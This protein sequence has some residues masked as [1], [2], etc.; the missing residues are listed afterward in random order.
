MMVEQMGMSDVV[1]PRNV[2]SGQQNP[3]MMG[4]SS[5]GFELKNKVDDEIDRILKEQYERGMNLLTEHRDLLDAI[6]NTLIEKEKIDGTQMLNIIKDL[7]PNLVSEEALQRAKET[8][9]EAVDTVTDAVTGGD[10]QT[11]QPAAMS[12]TELPSN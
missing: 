6:A 10:D 8:M 11:L 2:S 9:R 5:E 12:K 1:G 3:M 4:G 7:K